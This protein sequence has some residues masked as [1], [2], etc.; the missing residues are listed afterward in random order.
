MITVGLTGNVAGGKTSVAERWR[1]R[2]VLVVDA[3][4]LGHEVLREEPAVREALVEEFGEGILAA[5]GE[6]DRAA[7]GVRAFASPEATRR[8]NAIV[9]PPLL[10][11]L[12]Q[13]LERARRGGREIVAVDAALIFE[14]GLD[15]DLDLVVLVTAPPEVRAERLRLERGLEPQ[16]I[17]RIMASQ[18]P[19]AAKAGN[20]DFVLVNDGSLEDLRAKADAVL[21]A[22]RRRTPN[23]GGW[24][25]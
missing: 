6:I 1:E 21:D 24:D 25:G 5:D 13:E 15:E 4:R 9:H 11:R 8:L 2:G 23:G 18:Q 16:R 7:L 20:S 3:D 12:D 14:F 22:I 10:A 17:E 19:D